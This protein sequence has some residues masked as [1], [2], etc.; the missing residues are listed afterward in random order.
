MAGMTAW[1]RIV[2]VVM[3]LGLTGCGPIFSLHRFFSEDDVVFEPA[4]LGLWVDDDGN[5]WTVRADGSDGYEFINT[6][7]FWDTEGFPSMNATLFRLGETLF[8]D[9]APG[10]EGNCETCEMVDMPALFPAIP[11]HMVAVVDLGDDTLALGTLDEDWVREQIEKGRMEIKHER[12]DDGIF[13]TA[14]TGSLR[15]LLLRAAAEEGG[16]EMDTIWRR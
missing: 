2:V 15:E 9:F 13:L 11:V 8:I 7:A 5:W 3:L 4:L 6:P 14:S 16:F 1:K 10:E 12:T